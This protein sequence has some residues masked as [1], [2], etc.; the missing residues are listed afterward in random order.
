MPDVLAIITGERGQREIVRPLAAVDRQCLVLDWE[1][2]V[3]RE[4]SPYLGFIR[5]LWALV[6]AHR[7][8]IS[9]VSRETMLPADVKTIEVTR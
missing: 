7:G 3:A 9:Y 4:A 8:A 6:R 5:E 1:Q 2:L